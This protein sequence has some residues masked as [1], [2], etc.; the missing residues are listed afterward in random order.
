[1]AA[2]CRYP[3]SMTIRLNELPA[4]DFE[5]LLQHSLPVR[6]GDRVLELVVESVWRSPYPTGRDIPG[7]SL[8]L[9]GP[10]EARIEQGI[11]VVTHPVHGELALFMTPVGRDA[12]GMRYEIVFN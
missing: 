5:A 2:G 6:A 11:V 1:M 9:R 10:R 7:F 12:A 4:D 3:S 8:F